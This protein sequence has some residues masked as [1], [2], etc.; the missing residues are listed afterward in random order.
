MLG[1]P[2]GR[3]GIRGEAAAAQQRL[4]AGASQRSAEADQKLAQ[5]RVEANR[6]LD[7]A[8]AELDKAEAAGGQPEPRPAAAERGP[9]SATRRPPPG[10]RPNG[11]R[12]RRLRT[13]EEDFEITLRARRTDDRAAGPAGPPAEARGPARTDRVRGTR[14]GPWPSLTERQQTYQQLVG[15]LHAR[16]GAVLSRHRTLVTEPAP[17]A[18]AELAAAVSAVPRAELAEPAAAELRR[19]RRRPA[20]R[21]RLRPPAARASPP[22]RRSGWG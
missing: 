13:A 1:R 15:A 5:A 14:S 10:R 11:P 12:P 21:R 7:Q 16:L 22:T 19:A 18:A 2:P 20:G 8:T 6:I 4:T 17:P 3:R 9:G